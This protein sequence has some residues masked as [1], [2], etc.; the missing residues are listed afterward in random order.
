MNTAAP[1]GRSRHENRTR[2]VLISAIVSLSLLGDALLYAV[3]PSRPEAFGLRIWQIGVLLGANRL[4][5]LVTN[6]LAGR[7]V[8][9]SESDRPLYWAILVGSLITVS[10]ALPIGFWGLLAARLAWGACWSLL[11]VEGYLTA[12]VISSTRTRG[13]IFAIYQ[14]ATRVGQ[15]GGVLIGGLLTDAIGIAPTFLIFGL[16]TLSGIILLIKAPGR[17]RSYSAAVSSANEEPSTASQVPTTTAAPDKGAPIQGRFK[18]SLSVLISFLGTQPLH[19][20]GCALTLTMT[21][22]MIANLTG[23][24]VAERIG[25]I[26]TPSFGITSL[27]GLLLGFRSFGA[28]LLSPLAGVAS[29]R[30]GRRPLLMIMIGLQ[31][32]FIT[33]IALF[34]TWPL[35]VACM[36]LQFAVGSAIYLLIYTLA[37]DTAILSEQALHMSR[38]SSFLDLGTSLGPIVGFAIY[39]GYGFIW[40]AVL[41]WLLI[42][43][44]WILLRRLP[45]S[46]PQKVY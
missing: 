1:N 35:L 33:G 7:L 22:Q 4:V 32:C 5:R 14:A 26:L 12:L 8:Q 29:D 10:Y 30:F 2:F 36:L 17:P 44:A 23:L 6:E 38:F 16:A 40:V 11:R 24:L 9:R 20:W 37:G 27:T 21:E 39:G 28:L 31:A 34:R 46:P 15:G 41:S 18:S 19:L 43:T 3:L 25:P 42:L 45:A 13:R